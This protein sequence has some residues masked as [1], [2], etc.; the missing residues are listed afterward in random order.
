MSGKGARQRRT[1]KRRLERKPK[2]LEVIKRPPKKYSETIGN[3]K[4]LILSFIVLACATVALVN[5]LW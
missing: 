1:A 4:G 2:I 5:V 3:P